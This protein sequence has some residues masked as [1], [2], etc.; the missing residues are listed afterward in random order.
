[1]GSWKARGNQYIQ[2]IRLLYCKLPTNSK[3]L[4]AFPLN[5]VPGTE[6]QPQRWEARVLPLCH[7]SPGYD[8]KHQ[9]IMLSFVGPGLAFVVY[10]AT[11]S[12]MP[13]APF[14]AILFF[15]MLGTLGLGT[16]VSL[17]KII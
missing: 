17:V 13:A 4:P 15:F 5:A 8:I 16:M 2:F 1:M 3:Q 14:W 10:P 6:P 12:L 7:C 11:I 9:A